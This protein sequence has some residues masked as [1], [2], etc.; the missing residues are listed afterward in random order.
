MKQIDVIAVSKMLTPAFLKEFRQDILS[1]ETAEEFMEKIK[2]E[3]I[4]SAR[5]S[6]LANDYVCTYTVNA[7]DDSYYEFGS[8]VKPDSLGFA[9]EGQHFFDRCIE[10]GKRIIHEDDYPEFVKKFDKSKVM[11]AIKK[12][13]SFSLS[14]RS[15]PRK[16]VLP[17]QNKC[18]PQQ[19]RLPCRAAFII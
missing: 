15:T 9:K 17:H 3:Q 4:A 6:A 1:S 12:N 19:K 11:K 10:E 2:R 5:L 13:G 7:E 14:Y 16:Q 18:A 8:R